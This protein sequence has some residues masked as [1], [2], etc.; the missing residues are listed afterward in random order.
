MTKADLFQYIQAAQVPPHVRALAGLAIMRATQ[1]QI[2]QLAP[3]IERI[4]IAIQAKNPQGILEALND[5][6]VNTTAIGQSWLGLFA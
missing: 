5:A 4:Q 2:D 3:T 1:A 6:G